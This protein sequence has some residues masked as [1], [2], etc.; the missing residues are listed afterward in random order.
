MISRII[1]KSNS[2]LCRSLSTTS[3]TNLKV[4]VLGAAGSIGQPLS[5]LLKQCSMIDD[6]RLALYDIVNT[7]VVAAD[8]AHINTPTKVF[9][10]HGKENLNEALHQSDIIIISGGMSRKPGMIREDLYSIP[11]PVL[12]TNWEQQSQIIVLKQLSV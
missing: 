8:I 1:T 9:G 4:T 5:L 11:M 2:F 7:P 12:Y 6:D 3:Q 10:F